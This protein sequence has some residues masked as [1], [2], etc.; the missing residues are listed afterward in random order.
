MTVYAFLLQL[1]RFICSDFCKMFQVSNS[2][3]VLMNPDG[4]RSIKYVKCYIIYSS[5]AFN[6]FFHV[7]MLGKNARRTG[8]YLD[9]YED[10]RT[11]LTTQTI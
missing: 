10:S 9:I 1:I 7:R 8:V 2:A 4:N 6:K 5:T 11:F 3:Y